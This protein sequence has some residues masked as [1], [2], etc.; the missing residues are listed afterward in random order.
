MFKVTDLLRAKCMFASINDINGCCE[1]LK[2]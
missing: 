1:E 2:K